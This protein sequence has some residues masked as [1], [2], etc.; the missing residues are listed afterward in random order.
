VVILAKRKE[1]PWIEK[2]RPK[3]L[4]EVIGQEEVISVLKNFKSITELP[5]TLFTGPPGVGKTTVAHCLANYLGVRIVEH[6]ASDERGIEFIRT[7]LKDELTHAPPKIILLDE[8]DELTEA[9]QTALRRLME[10]YIDAPNRLVLT[11]NYPWRII[12]PLQSRCLTFNFKPLPKKQCAQF[13]LKIMKN[14][15][16]LKGLDKEEVKEILFFLLDLSKGD[17]RKAINTLQ[18][19]HASGVKVSKVEISKH[20]EDIILA[21]QLIRKA[22]ESDDWNEIRALLEQVLIERGLNP[23][24]V[25]QELYTSAFDVINDRVVLAKFLVS[26]KMTDGFLSYPNTNPLVQLASCLMEL[27]V[28][29]HSTR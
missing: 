11:A 21:R 13:L 14:E 19:I 24:T 7:K 8:A 2:Y 9:A 29:V 6:N 27:N 1:R 3:T 18:K 22:V 26:L 28:I 10:Q 15:G 25:I 12:E 20:F 17:L 5:H 23:R 4:D 16:M